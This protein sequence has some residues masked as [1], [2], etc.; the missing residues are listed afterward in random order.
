MKPRV[1]QTSTHVEK[2]NRTLM[3][4]KAAMTCPFNQTEKQKAP[5]E[6]L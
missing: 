2:G 3:R 5:S 4:R 1:T 6:K